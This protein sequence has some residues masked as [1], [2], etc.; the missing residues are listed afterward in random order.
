M[1]LG[2]IPVACQE[3]GKTLDQLAA[4]SASDDIRME[5]HAKDGIYELLCQPCGDRYARLRMDLY[6]KTPFSKAHR[7]D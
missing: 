7:L 2:E 5:V 3:C 6:G 4:E 1:F